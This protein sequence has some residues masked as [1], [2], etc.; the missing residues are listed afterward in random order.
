MKIRRIECVFHFI[1]IQHPKRCEKWKIKRNNYDM[2]FLKKK[3]NDKN[4]SMKNIKKTK[5]KNLHFIS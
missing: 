1:A 2:L 5:K 3:I 4:N